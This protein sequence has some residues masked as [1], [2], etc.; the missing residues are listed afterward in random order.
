M[1]ESKFD[2]FRR[3]GV[4][5]HLIEKLAPLKDRDFDG[6]VQTGNALQEMLGPDYPKI[7]EAEFAT[8]GVYSLFRWTLDDIVGYYADGYLGQYLLILPQHK[9]VAVRMVRQ[10]STY[11]FETDQFPDFFNR[12]QALVN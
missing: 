12:V 11:S 10:R 3:A 8:K 2:E 9:L 4:A 6:G 5:S 1:D 7:R